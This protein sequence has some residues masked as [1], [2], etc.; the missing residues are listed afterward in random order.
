MIIAN[1]ILLGIVALIC[2]AGGVNILLKGAAH[3]L[4]KDIPP[5]LVLDDLVRFLGG[6]YFS[7]GFL[8]AYTAFHVE[9]VGNITYFLGLM[10][11]FSGLGR[12]YSTYKVGSAGR[13]FDFIMIVEILLGIFIIGLKW[14][15]T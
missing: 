12:L 8:F 7:A 3:F 1:T 11:V 6:I 10:V 4:P 14:I 5:Q 13:Y 15:E 9:E 2:F